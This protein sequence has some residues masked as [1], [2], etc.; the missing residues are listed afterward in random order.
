MSIESETARTGPSRKWYRALPRLAP[1]RKAESL[2]AILIGVTAVTATL[3]TWRAT[4]LSGRA[5]RADARFIEATTAQQDVRVATENQVRQEMYFH[6]QAAGDGRAGIELAA[7][8]GAAPLDTREA[9]DLYRRAIEQSRLYFYVHD[10]LLPKAY[11]EDTASG[12]DRREVFK[13]GARREDLIASRTSPDSPDPGG[14]SRRADAFRRESLSFGRGSV[15]LV[16]VV[17]LL[18]VAECS[19]GRLR[20][21]LAYGGGGA[22]V[23]AVGVTLV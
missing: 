19:R 7:L 1:V 2:I 3:F 5:G 4:T 21:W 8:A 16:A 23:L 11:L 13:D 18:T 12:L 6:I 14:E 15:A 22:F 9:R 10:G 20:R 17:A